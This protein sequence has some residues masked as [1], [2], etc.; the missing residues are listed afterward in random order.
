MM[1]CASVATMSLATM[2][3]FED[4]MVC[5]PALRSVDAELLDMTLTSSS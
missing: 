2:A 5:P 1:S 4:V 3:V